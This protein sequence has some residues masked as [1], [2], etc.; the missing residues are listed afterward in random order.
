MAIDDF[1]NF[2]AWVQK[3]AAGD[4]SLRD[5]FDQY[6]ATYGAAGLTPALAAMGVAAAVNPQRIPLIGAIGDSRVYHIF[7]GALTPPTPPTSGNDA[8]H[9][10][11]SPLFWASFYSRGRYRTAPEVCFG[12][13]GENAEQIA[14]RIQT[15]ITA[16]KLY[17]VTACWMPDP[18]NSFVGNSNGIAG[19]TTCATALKAA[20][21]TLITDTPVPRGGD[22]GAFLLTDDQVKLQMAYAAWLNGPLARA[23]G[24]VVNDITLALY[25][26]TAV[27]FRD[28]GTAAPLTPLMDRLHYGIP[29]AQARGR[30]LQTQ[31]DRL[32]YSFAPSFTSTGDVYDAALNPN[33]NLVANPRLR[34]TTGTRNAA[35]GAT[36]SGNV[37]TGFDLSGV[38]G[39][40]LT[41]TASKT[42]DDVQQIVFSGTPTGVG[43]G[44]YFSRT[45]SAPELAYFN[46]GDVVEPISDLEIDAGHTCIRGLELILTITDASGAHSVGAGQVIA[47]VSAMD[48]AAAVGT[49]I[50]PRRTIVGTVTGAVLTQRVDFN[51]NVVAAATMRIPSLSL[52]KVS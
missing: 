3:Q 30:A 4:I 50:A 46:N 27:G 12:V 13:A 49:I 52:R 17:G 38:T 1:Q 7:G 45:L 39:T 29:G 33:G 44:A 11:R 22:G 36:L 10:I 24:I 2:A 25:D 18:T 42:A 34:G 40:G 21:I 35:N 32:F 43:S 28:K 5:V 51:Q 48:G 14:A 31:L 26:T 47:G 41:I 8:R 6:L 16:F 19:M 23:L 20:G 9:S 15:A 37:A